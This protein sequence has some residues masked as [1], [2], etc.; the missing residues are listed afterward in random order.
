MRMVLGFILTLKRIVADTNK[1]AEM[2][3]SPDSKSI[4]TLL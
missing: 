3:F 2:T 4:K 1:A